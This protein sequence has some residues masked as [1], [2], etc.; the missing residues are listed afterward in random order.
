MKNIWTI[1]IIGAYIIYVTSA[2][3]STASL[4]VS[5]PVKIVSSIDFTVYKIIDGSNVV[6]ITCSTSDNIN[7]S[8]AVVK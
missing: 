8:M 6:Y 5:S 7:V 1:L 4:P 2:F 3:S